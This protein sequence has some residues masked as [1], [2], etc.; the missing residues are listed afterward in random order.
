LLGRIGRREQRRP[1]L[2]LRGQKRP[3]ARAERQLQRHAVPDTAVI[4]RGQSGDGGIFVRAVE[5]ADRQGSFEADRRIG[6]GRGCQH[7]DRRA[8]ASS[9]DGANRG[10]AIRTPCRRTCGALSAKAVSKVLA[11]SFI[12][13]VERP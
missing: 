3:G 9:D 13:A 7:R 10:A 5:I 12:Q 8:G 1:G 11:S 2:N 6:I 4:E